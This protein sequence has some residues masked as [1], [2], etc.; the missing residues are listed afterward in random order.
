MLLCHSFAFK[1]F[2]ESAIMKG[3]RQC[4]DTPCIVNDSRPTFPY[5]FVNGALYRRKAAFVIFPMFKHNSF[6]SRF[7]SMV[8][9]CVCFA[10][11]DAPVCPRGHCTV[12]G[13][14]GASDGATTAVCSA[15]PG[16]GDG[17]VRTRCLPVGPRRR[18]AGSGV[19]S[20]TGSTVLVRNRAYFSREMW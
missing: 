14:H 17:G 19:L 4:H 16:F 9:S 7:L 18:T 3:L 20:D 8:S 11:E 15:R 2:T 1:S 12:E 13:A 5:F 6:Q 10:L